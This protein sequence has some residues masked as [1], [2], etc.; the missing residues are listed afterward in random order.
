M[1]EK[2]DTVY[3]EHNVMRPT[4]KTKGGFPQQS[5]APNNALKNC[6]EKK[7]DVDDTIVPD[8][9][10]LDDKSIGRQFGLIFIHLSPDQTSLISL[11]Y[12]P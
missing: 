3:T 11:P 12:W 1:I 7:G 2:E 5:F 10:C 6:G 8:T 9:V 4:R